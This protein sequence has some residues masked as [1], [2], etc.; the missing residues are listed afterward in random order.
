MR[1]CS[2]VILYSYSWKYL[3]GIPIPRLNLH[4]IL[5]LFVSFYDYKTDETIN[6]N[7]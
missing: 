4:K 3:C 2:V 5:K 7:T 1:I 6:M